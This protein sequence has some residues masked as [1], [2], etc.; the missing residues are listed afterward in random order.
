[1]TRKPWT[2]A[3]DAIIVKKYSFMGCKIAPLLPNRTN[4]AIRTRARALGCKY[5]GRNW[6]AEE[7]AVLRE[8][9]P[10]MGPDVVAL[11]PERAPTTVMYMVHSLRLHRSPEIDRRY[12]ANRA[13]AWTDEED[14]ILR[15]HYTAMGT[16]VSSL[17]P[18]RS[19]SSI[20]TRAYA[21]GIPSKKV[22]S[23]WTDEE[24]QMLREYVPII[25]C[26]ET[27]HLFIRNHSFAA[28]LNKCEELGL[29]FISVS[30]TWTDEELSILF[31]HYPEI[32]LDVCKLLPN[33]SI[34]S[35]QRKVS[36]LGI[37][38]LRPIPGWSEEDIS[39]LCQ[40]YPK[41]GIA[42]QNRLP[43]KH[44]R[45][46][47]RV[48]RKMGLH[49][50]SYDS[51]GIS[52]IRWTAEEDNIL[53]DYFPSMGMGVSELL[54]HREVSAIVRR[55]KKIGADEEST[56]IRHLTDEQEKLLRELYPSIG[57]AVQHYLPAFSLNAIHVYVMALVIPSPSDG[58]KMPS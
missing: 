44:L 40:Y 13:D 5:E 53:R 43:E 19:I 57:D 14:A 34:N 58:N 27:Q 31:E 20:R 38:H 11:F 17:L 12:R 37:V 2:P 21:L 52:P 22:F 28:C 33:R 56:R 29:R 47:K 54:P 18:N 46:I 25:G 4:D 55:A 50:P 8:H 39:I 32:G 30:P 6:T 36:F 9:Y 15:E 24:I 1:M 3:E 10:L 26:E 45:T 51:K 16:M 41:E 48:A 23:T 42:V 7:I 35:I 49:P